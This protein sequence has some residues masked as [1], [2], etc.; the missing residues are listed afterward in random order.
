M[1][2][3]F[4]FFEAH[5]PNIGVIGMHWGDEGKGKI[6][7]LLAEFFDVVAR[8]QG[9]HNAGHSVVIE[10][11]KFAMHLIPSGILRPGKICVIGNGTVIDPAAFL[12]EVDQLTGEGI[13]VAGRLFLS[14]RA[15]VILP[16][17][18]AVEEAMEA[19]KGNDCIGPTRRGIGPAYVTKMARSGI[20]TGDLLSR[21]SLAK[22]VEYGVREAERILGDRKSSPP[23]SV[24]KLVDDYLAYGKRLSACITDTSLVLHKMMQEGKT[25]LFEGAQGTMLDVDHGT[26]PFVTSSSSTAGG[27]CTG[28]GVSPK[29]VEGLLGVMKAY[30]TRVGNGPFPTELRNEIG[31]TI[32]ERGREYGVSTGRPRRCGWFDAV[33]ARYAARINDFDTAA[34]TLL[35]VLDEM[36]EIRIC[37]AY[38]L[39]GEIIR[40]VPARI[41][42][43]FALEPVFET[44]PGWRQSI[45]SCRRWE[46]L[47]RETQDYVA[48]LQD[49]TGVEISIVSVGPDRK[50]TIVR[51]S[52]SLRR[53]FGENVV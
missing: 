9:G 39:R 11:K 46:E 8:Y 47:P 34:L 19:L 3:A 16:Y 45:R 1:P 53:W 22:K 44:L 13:D 42:D 2:G 12:K 33:A 26:Y 35:D 4:F 43:H 32:R 29:R 41:E 30:C 27:I 48:R 6:V 14:G 10:N 49:L 15:H 40:E 28:L 17:H 20:R 24:E 38:R 18:I 52:K 25:I 51:E 5:M 21:E 37:T 7:D 50:N 36:Q 23:L 31:D